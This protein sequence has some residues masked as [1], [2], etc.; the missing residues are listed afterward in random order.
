[1][2]QVFGLPVGGGDDEAERLR[3]AFAYRGGEIG[4][5]GR[6]GSGDGSY[7][8]AG[9]TLGGSC[10]LRSFRRGCSGAAGLFLVARVGLMASPESWCERYEL[11]E[12]D[13]LVG[14]HS[15]TPFSIFPPLV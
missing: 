11:S 14:R 4:Q 10:R 5:Q 15:Q 3:G 2:G 1:M 12:W 6:V 7:E 8:G 9:T 13:E